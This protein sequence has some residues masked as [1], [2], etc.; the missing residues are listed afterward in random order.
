MP[1]QTPR[2]RTHTRYPDL[3]LKHV[4]TGPLVPVTIPTSSTSS[5]PHLGSRLNA[6]GAV[7]WA[8][9]VIFY[10]LLLVWLQLF[11]FPPSTHFIPNHRHHCCYSVPGCVYRGTVVSYP[12]EPRTLRIKSATIGPA[13]WSTH[14]PDAP[15]SLAGAWGAT[16]PGAP[17]R[18]LG[19]QPRV[20]RRYQP[21]QTARSLLPRLTPLSPQLLLSSN[22][23]V[24]ARRK[25]SVFPHGMVCALI[26]PIPCPPPQ[27]GLCT[28]CP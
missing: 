11:S 14:R 23:I 2:A 27:D 16:H 28:Q 10:V 1:M 13:S 22:L 25:A 3:S 17:R 9:A 24:P 15:W 4:N 20:G 7:H 19:E 12:D 5:P 6:V 21:A 26:F 18:V 8:A